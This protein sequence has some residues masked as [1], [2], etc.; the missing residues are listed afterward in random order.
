MDPKDIGSGYDEP[1]DVSALMQGQHVTLFSLLKLIALQ[2]AVLNEN[3]N[4]TGNAGE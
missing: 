2:L 1:A 4:Q 3:P